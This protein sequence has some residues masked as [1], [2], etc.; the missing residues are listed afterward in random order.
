MRYVPCDWRDK[1][2]TAADGDGRCVCAPRINTNASREG[3]PRCE[4]RLKPQAQPH[5]KIAK[6][7]KPK[8]FAR[9]AAV[10]S[11]R[12]AGGLLSPPYTTLAR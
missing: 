5:A 10:Q 3:E 12:W 1:A 7:A 6:I 8:T 4:K 2:P 11:Y 9:A